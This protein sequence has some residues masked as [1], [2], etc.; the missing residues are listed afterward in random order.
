MNGSRSIP[1][2]QGENPSIDALNR[3][4]QGLEARIEGL[5]APAREPRGR[6]EFDRASDSVS[7][8]LL[9][10]R[11]LAN[12]RVPAETHLQRDDRFIA[13]EVRTRLPLASSTVQH[14]AAIKSTDVAMQDIAQALVGLRHELKKDITEGVSREVQNLRAEIRGIKPTAHDQNFAVDMRDDLAKLAESINRLG[15]QASPSEAAG[16]RAEF[17]ELRSAIDGLAREDSIRQLNSR[18]TGVEEKLNTFNPAALQEDLLSLAYQL[19]DIKSHMGSMSAAPAVHALESRLISL[20]NQIESMGAQMQPNDRVIAQQFAGLDLRLDEISRAIAAASRTSSNA[21]D[22]QILRSFESKINQLAGAIE[23]V[24]QPQVDRTI[25]PRIEALAQRVE[26][27]LGTAS[28]T[29][30]DERLDQLSRVMEN[31]LRS[32]NPPELAYHLSDISRKIDA[33]DTGSVNNELAK[34]LG[35]LARRIEEFST[36]PHVVTAD[37]SASMNRLEDRLDG[38]AARLD[39]AATAAPV[40][41]S[42]D[43]TAFQNLEAQI[44]NLS[45]L[46]HK[47]HSAAPGVAPEIEH[48]MAALEDYIATSDEF[49]MQAARQ[50]AEAVAEAYGRHSD[51]QNAAP[52]VD[53]AMFNALSEDLQHL[54]EITR[55]SEQRTHKTFSALHDTLVQIAHRLDSMDGTVTAHGREGSNNAQQPIAA[56]PLPQ[57]TKQFPEN[58]YMSAMESAGMAVAKQANVPDR[59]PERSVDPMTLVESAR[60]DFTRLQAETEMEYEKKARSIQQSIIAPEPQRTVVQPPPATDAFEFYP[61]SADDSLLLEPGS[62]VP[63]V[64]K[65]LAKVRASQNSNAAPSAPGK[66]SDSEKADFISAARRAAREAAAEIENSSVDAP[67]RGMAHAKDSKPESMIAKNRR[68]LLLTAGLVVLGVLAYPMLKTLVLGKPSPAQIEMSQTAAPA[69]DAPAAKPNDANAPADTTNAMAPAADTGKAPTNAANDATK[70]MDATDSAEP[71]KAPGELMEKPAAE[72]SM[73]PAAALPGAAADGMGAQPDQP[74]PQPAVS[75]VD[76]PDNVGPPTLVTAARSGDPL[77]LFEIGARFTDG[78]GVKADMGEAAKWYQKAA[79]KGQAVAQ[80][81]LANFYEKGTGIQ[82]DIAKAKSLYEQS[83]KQGNA[84]AMHNLAVLSATGVD[85]KPDMVSA[86]KWFKQAADMG[87]K[88]SQ[89]N[90]AIL[91]A[92][93]TGVPADLTESYKWFA[94]A[95][96]DGDADAGQKR[97]EVAKA[98]KPDQLTSAKAK[99][100]AWKKEPVNDA[101]NNPIVPDDW[102]GKGNSTSSIDMKKAITNIQAILNN[103]GYSVGKPD[104]KMGAKT[105]AAIKSFQASVGQNPTGEI[106]DALVKELLARNKKS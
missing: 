95:A 33:L 63:D 48:R 52:G 50:A 24:Q 76:V 31:S 88:D 13:D 23:L 15:H 54:E 87:V 100:E 8:I 41:A 25:A 101:T 6:N 99:V 19:D 97:D 49:I 72:N 26:E 42:V 3:T 92:R 70:S 94:I 106:T 73:T 43:H 16:L 22:P 65:I 44:A 79:E 10:Q 39:F 66:L 98:M 60:Q 104:G 18:W 34:Q 17:N 64:K 30:L 12:S 80:Y 77:A 1:L 74:A 36:K 40:P 90:L 67:S 82:R 14:A 28:A 69:T 89:F 45:N 91:Y 2:R 85:G 20:A 53:L 61:P 86:G 27:L 32:D 7:E 103:N 55:S 51:T 68:A 84:S 5:M 71:G 46:L 21:L 105:V 58:D 38:I 9:R 4:I 78:R 81:R 35:F 47:S 57:N 102:I 59:Y 75:V 29:R 11:S 37:N 62:G 83:A 96:R 56:K 93:G